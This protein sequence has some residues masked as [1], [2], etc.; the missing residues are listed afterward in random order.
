MAHQ[1]LK[2][3]Q[4]GH[5]ARVE[6]FSTIDAG[7]RRKLMAYGLLP[8]I[9]IDLLQVRPNY[10]IRIDHMELAIDA[11]VAAKIYISKDKV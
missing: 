5:R 9:M 11:E 3:L 10:V 1:T 8:G 6:A 2:E 7:H 4:V